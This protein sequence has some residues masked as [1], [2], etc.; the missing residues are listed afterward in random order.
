MVLMSGL[1]TTATVMVVALP[2][3]VAEPVELEEPDA[4]PDG[5]AVF[6]DDDPHADKTSE[7]TEATARIGTIAVRCLLRRTCTGFLLGKATT[8]QP[9]D[10]L[11]H[12]SSR[13]YERLI[14]SIEH[15]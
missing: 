8:S 13:S 15:P 10:R 2:P 5:D 12:S 6:F 3:A 14:C 9:T 7:P 4:V 1:S 11:A